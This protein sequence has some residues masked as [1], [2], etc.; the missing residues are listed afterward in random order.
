MGTQGPRLE[1]MGT[2]GKPMGAVPGGPDVLLTNENPWKLMG[3]HKRRW[4]AMRNHGT[5]HGKSMGSLGSSCLGNPWE[6]MEIH[7]N[8]YKPMESHWK[9][10]GSPREAMGIHGKTRYAVESHRKPLE[11]MERH[12]ELWAPMGTVRNHMAIHENPWAPLGPVLLLLSSIVAVGSPS[13]LSF[14]RR[15]GLSLDC[16]HLP[17]HYVCNMYVHDEP[18]HPDLDPVVPFLVHTLVTPL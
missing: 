7:R 11:D 4:E 17:R 14:S 8:P 5:N 3:T 10:M 9:P 15:R 1:S 12:E 18:L 6:P 13:A 2:Q 16:V